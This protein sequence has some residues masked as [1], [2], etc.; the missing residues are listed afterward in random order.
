MSS[1]ENLV[2]MEAAILRASGTGQRG[3]VCWWDAFALYATTHAA[4][5]LADDVALR[6]Y[7]T[8]LRRVLR[9]DERFAGL[10][11]LQPP[12]PPPTSRKRS[13]KRG[14]L[15]ALLC[16]HIAQRD[17]RPVGMTITRRHPAAFATAVAVTAIALA[18]RRRRLSLH[19][20]IR[21]ALRS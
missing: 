13:P 12:T 16:A 9:A 2:A 20:R 21:R 17:G 3:G 6:R 19:L 10:G 7:V 4:T 8:S 14:G 1:Q 11:A 5:S 15:R 18:P